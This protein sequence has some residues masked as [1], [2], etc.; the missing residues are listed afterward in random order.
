ML[1]AWQSRSMISNEKTACY[2]ELITDMDTARD[3]RDQASNLLPRWGVM[4]DSMSVSDTPDFLQSLESMTVSFI[5]ENGDILAEETGDYLG[6]NPLQGVLE[7]VNELRRKG[8]VLQ[9]GDLVSSGSYMPP[10]LVTPGME[11]ITRYEGIGGQR[12]EVSASYQ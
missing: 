7:V 12:L 1:T 8:E 6:G 2:A 10:I 9:S 4:G 3:L 5:D 11:T